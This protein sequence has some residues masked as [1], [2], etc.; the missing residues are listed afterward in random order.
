MELIVPLLRTVVAVVAVVGLL[1]WVGRRMSGQAP[2]GAGARPVSQWRRP[3][4]GRASGAGAVLGAGSGAGRGSRTGFAAS[5]RALLERLGERRPA[6]ERELRVVDRTSLTPRASLAL[7]EVGGRRL[8]LGVGDQGISV[9]D[10]HA[11]PAAAGP[12]AEPTTDVTDV[13]AATVTDFDDILQRALAPSSDGAS[14]R[15]GDR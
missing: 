10:T 14:G 2:A 6:P 12:A 15:A 11:A 3:A 8:L 1:W 13:A 7:V 9:L 5:W 4:A